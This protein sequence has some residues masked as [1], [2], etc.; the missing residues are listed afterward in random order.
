MT[1]LSNIPI[2]LTDPIATPRKPN[3]K[4]GQKDPN[5]GKITDAWIP[6]FNSFT[7]NFVGVP[8]QANSPVTLSAQTDSIAVTPVPSGSLAPGL[9]RMTY[10][11]RVTSAAGVA[12]S[13]QVIFS[14][15]DGGVSCTF[16]GTVFNGNLTTT[17]GSQTA[18]FNIDAASPVS[19]STAYTSNPA[20]A[21]TYELFVILEAL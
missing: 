8:K 18:T 21:M 19:Y 9:Y 4:P 3:L 17:V 1:T 2:P 10:F 11:V 6:F 16:P 15:T 20:N 7:Q 14:F 5:E 13:I 12:S